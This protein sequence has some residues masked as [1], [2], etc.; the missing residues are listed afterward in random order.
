ML[1]CY[2]TVLLLHGRDGSKLRRSAV[3]IER[4]AFLAGFYK[5]FALGNGPCD[6]CESCALDAKDCR[7]PGE[8]RPAM[9]ACGIDVFMTAR[10]AEL[11]IEVVTA[12]SQTAN[13]YAAVLLE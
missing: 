10:T 5:A 4:E 9:E 8:S 12:T 11:P 2:Q 3:Q 6:L 7:H 13:Y 1:D